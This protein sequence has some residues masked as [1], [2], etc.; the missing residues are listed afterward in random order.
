MAMFDVDKF[1]KSGGNLQKI[2]PDLIAASNKKTARRD[3]KSEAADV[4]AAKTGPDGKTTPASSAATTTTPADGSAA[5]KS[6][7]EGDKT[8]D[9]A[10]GEVK[11]AVTEAED[12]TDADLDALTQLASTG[13][14][15]P[16]SG[17]SGK[18]AFAGSMSP[19]DSSPVR[20]DSS[21]RAGL[22]DMVDEPAVRLEPVSMKAEK[23]DQ[24]GSRSDKMDTGEDN[25]SSSN[26]SSGKKPATKQQ[27][28]GDS[29]PA[30]GHSDQHAAAQS[31]GSGSSSS[32]SASN[33]AVNQ[34]QSGSDGNQE[35]ASAE[36]HSAA[37]GEEP[38]ADGT[39]KGSRKRK[40][41]S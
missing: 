40:A 16:G 35:L 5:G 9:K 15:N 13:N 33:S 19:P 38:G 6:E 3:S 18:D 26:G 25:A 36:D 7:K 24:P 4:K 28:G 23:S 20:D 12:A 37:D 11:L 39:R 10:E 14:K 30:A 34:Q 41:P 21:G 22:D 1:A 29:T 31:H 2:M 27:A 32:S 17:T 8:A